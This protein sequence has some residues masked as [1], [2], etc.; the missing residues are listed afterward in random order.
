MFHFLHN[1]VVYVPFSALQQSSTPLSSIVEE[2]DIDRPIDILVLG[3]EGRSRSWLYKRFVDL[4]LKHELTVLFSMD[5]EDHDEERENFLI[6]D[7]KVSCYI[8]LFDYGPSFLQFFC[9]GDCKS[10]GRKHR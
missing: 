3:V 6:N 1:N 2:R 9:P 5:F 7:A 10:A 8:K 4:A